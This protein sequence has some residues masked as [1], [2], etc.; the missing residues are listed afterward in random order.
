VRSPGQAF[1]DPEAPLTPVSYPAVTIGDN[2][3]RFLPPAAVPT[4]WQTASGSAPT[5]VQAAGLP[6]SAYPVSGWPTPAVAPS[7]VVQ[8]SLSA[9]RPDASPKRLA[10][11]QD[12]Q[13]RRQAL[14][15]LRQLRDELRNEQGSDGTREEAIRALERTIEAVENGAAPTR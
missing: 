1:A 9:S 6:E 7:R 4:S 2:S 13:Q 8:T 5:P 12:Q 10:A 15:E 14:A 11:E 3:I